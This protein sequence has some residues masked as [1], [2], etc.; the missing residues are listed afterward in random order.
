MIIKQI[1]YTW[2]HIRKLIT[3]HT[4]KINVVIPRKNAD[5][6]GPSIKSV[7]GRKSNMLASSDFQ[8]MENYK[9]LKTTEIINTI[10]TFFSNYLPPG[11][12]SHVVCDNLCNRFQQGNG[13]ET[14]DENE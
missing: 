7:R 2:L 9:K 12:A 13:L 4:D 14:R 8:W 6:K 5:S 3:Y 11:S 10:N 1:S